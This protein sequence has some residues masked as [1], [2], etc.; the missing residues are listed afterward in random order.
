MRNKRVVES[1]HTPSMYPSRPV[2][3]RKKIAKAEE[4][5]LFG[6]SEEEGQVQ[7]KVVK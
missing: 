2:R 3:E 6:V 7:V 1:K 4:N 5:K